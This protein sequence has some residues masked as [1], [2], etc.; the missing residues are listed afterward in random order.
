[1]KR[2]V[3]GPTPKD[4]EEDSRL[5]Y[6]RQNKVYASTTIRPFTRVAVCAGRLFSRQEHIRLF[7]DGAR[8]DG[9][10]RSTVKRQGKT[11]LPG[12]VVSP[13]LPGGALDPK[14]ADTDM[15][16]VAA[17]LTP[18]PGR[19]REPTCIEVVN[20]LESRK[21]FWVGRHGAH[22]DQLLT[23]CAEDST[24]P[25][26]VITA[27]MARPVTFRE[28][29]HWTRHWT[30]YKEKV[31]KEMGAAY[32]PYAEY[33]TMPPVARSND[34]GYGND[35]LKKGLIINKTNI[36]N[37]DVDF[38]KLQH[39][40]DLQRANA[41]HS[42]PASA[43][44]REGFP[45]TAGANGVTR[46][47]ASLAGQRAYQTIASRFLEKTILRKC[48]E[49]GYATD[50]DAVN[51]LHKFIR[52]YGLN[53]RTYNAASRGPDWWTLLHLASQLVGKTM[54]EINDTQADVLYRRRRDVIRA[55][56][57]G[58]YDLYQEFD[59][60]ADLTITNDPRTRQFWLVTL[61]RLL[62]RKLCSMLPGHKERR[63]AP[64]P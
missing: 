1:M 25:E 22:R 44:R 48:G 29:A 38:H 36:W 34:D 37:D 27:H 24:C 32:D 4:L 9:W 60:L 8:A 40:H 58:R 54:D 41:Y 6:I 17:F 56:P 11:R 19:N 43:R 47:A 49:L 23:V 2:S 51:L 53:A 46:Y 52:F 3:V 35:L 7:G 31:Y 5:Y 13:G 50:A 45:Y 57:P 62:N 42:I 21:E 63:N 30:P 18:V 64:A 14:F 15:F 28:L 16:G 33:A 10:A 61:A 12:Y 20:V 55:F 39:M 26:Y 59:K